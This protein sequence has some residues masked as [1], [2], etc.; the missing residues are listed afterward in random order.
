MLASAGIFA[1]SGPAKAATQLQ[2]KQSFKN[3]IAYILTHFSQFTHPEQ[4]YA[5]G[6]IWYLTDNGW[7]FYTPHGYVESISPNKISLTDTN[8]V[9]KASHGH[10]VPFVKA[11]I[12]RVVVGWEEVISPILY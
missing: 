4:T 12:F 11:V 6:S 3:S 8:D 2:V 9:G 10:C 7:N 5:G 1:I